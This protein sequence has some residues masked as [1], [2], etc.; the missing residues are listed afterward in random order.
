MFLSLSNSNDVDDLAVVTSG[1]SENKTKVPHEK[2][3]VGFTEAV[4]ARDTNAVSAARKELIDA[5]GPEG[6]VN[7]AAIAANFDGITRVADG[8][9]IELDPIMEGA[10]EELREKLGLHA[11]GS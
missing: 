8:I 1:S 7:A 5:L 4:H 3:L 9:G 2:A 6:T 10:T 11:F